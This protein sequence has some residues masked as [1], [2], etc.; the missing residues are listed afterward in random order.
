M[1]E[2]AAHLVPACLAAALL[3]A[4]GPASA[5]N[6]VAVSGS[7]YVDS[8]VIPGSAGQ[9]RATRG[10]TPDGSLKVGIDINDDLSFSAKAC[11]SCHGIELEH[12]AFDFQP[13]VWFNV[14]A[15]RLAIPFGEFSNRLDQSGH[16][17]VSAPLLYDMGRAAYA[18]RAE[19]NGPIVMLPY[20]DTGAMVYGQFFLG[21]AM[22]VWYGGWVVAG[23]KGA[24]DLDWMASRTVPY[25]DNNRVPSTGG[26]LALTLTSDGTR[27]IGDVSLG[28]SYTGGRYDRNGTLAYHA[29]ALDLA[30]PI[31]KATLRGE[32]AMRRTW[33]DPN[34][35]GYG[36]VLVDHFFD[37]RG[38]YAE[39]E[40]PLGR[41]LN[42]VYR[43]DR[44]DRLGVPLPGSTSAMTPRSRLERGTAGLVLTP[45]ASLF[46]KVSYEYWRS[47]LAPAF[48]SGHVGVGGA[49]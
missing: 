20:V 23:M 9:T 42:M 35:S 13:K 21:K 11:I 19:F 46:V 16:R 34:A 12:A 45:A 27:F 5:G 6:S 41:Y 3:L 8:W 43:Y 26:R 10:V 28:A 25:T 32:A 17:T 37:K 2:R 36:Y 49:F 18:D 14:Q 29:A 47:S 48:H 39:L 24:A 1:T 22:Q 38:W 30:I 40:H 44:L 15:G 4:A 31:W 7:F 33:L